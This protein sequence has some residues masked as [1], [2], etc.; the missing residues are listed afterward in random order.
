MWKNFESSY[1]LTFSQTLLL[2]LTTKGLTREAAY[3]LVQ[4]NAMQSWKTKVQLKSLVMKDTEIL[5]HLSKSELEIIFSPEA[6]MKKMKKNVD[7]I[8]KRTGLTV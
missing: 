3:Q 8:F 5:K 2:A 6:L 1:G 4:Q 7:T